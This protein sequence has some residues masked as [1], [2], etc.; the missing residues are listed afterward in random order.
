MDYIN[1]YQRIG[2]IKIKNMNFFK[3][4]H[5]NIWSIKKIF[6]TLHCQIKII[7][8]PTLDCGC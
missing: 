4:N 7:I 6:V 1:E 8:F 2:I 5:K 3:N